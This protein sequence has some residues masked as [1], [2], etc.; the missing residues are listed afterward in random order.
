[1]PLCGQGGHGR[2]PGSEGEQ[3]DKVVRAS[4]QGSKRGHGGVASGVAWACPCHADHGIVKLGLGNA[5]RGH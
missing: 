3:R 5:E 1:M 2:V 4:R